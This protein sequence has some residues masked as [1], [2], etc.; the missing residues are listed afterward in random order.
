MPTSQAKAPISAHPLFPA[1]VAVWFAAL[2]G[3]GSGVLPTVLFEHLITA[4]GISSLI[5]SATPPLGDTFRI[6]LSLTFAVIGAL[7][8]FALARRLAVAHYVERPEPVMSQLTPRPDAPP[9]DEGFG[10]LLTRSMVR[11][12]LGGEIERIWAPEGLTI[13]VRLDG[14]RLVSS[15][16]SL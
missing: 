14:A 11:S 16:H 3:F 2:F 12:Q 4:T 9:G 10:S 1:V 13:L 15:E 6:I 7:L 5:P 8:G